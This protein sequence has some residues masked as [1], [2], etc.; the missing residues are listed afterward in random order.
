MNFKKLGLLLISG[1]LLSV[2]LLVP[3]L[4]VLIWIAFVPLLLLIS[5]HNL[6]QS[7]GFGLFFGII[8]YTS[9]LYWIAQYEIRILTIV[10]I[11]TAPYVALFALMTRLL[12]NHYP[13]E[14]IRILAV[15]IVWFVI[16]FLYSFTPVD[17]V[18]NQ[19]AFLQAPH[20]PGILRI[21][22]LSGIT[23]L[24]LLINS[25]I[26]H[27]LLNRRKL[28]LI[29]LVLI[30]LL[31]IVGMTSK[32]HF[33]QTQPLRVAVVQHNFPIS[34]KWRSE[35]REKIMDTYQHSIRQLGKT[36]DLI[37]FPQYGL[38]I[39]ALREPKFFDRLAKHLDTSIILGTY[40]PEVAGGSL[41]SGTRTDSALV[42]SG[43]HSVQEYQA[44][45]APPFRKIGQVLGKDR[46][47]L[48]IKQVKAGIM[49]CYED[50]HAQEGRRWVL[51]GAQI[52]ISLSNPGHFLQ[53]H[54]PFY[55]LTHDRI[56]AIE[57]GKYVIRASPNGFSALINPNGELIK[58]SKLNEKVMLQGV[59]YP[60]DYETWFVRFGALLPNA[61]AA[62]G[63]IL[64][65]APYFL[66]SINFLA[67][68][69]R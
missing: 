10:L 56:K 68:K 4:S 66:S 44:L 57:T 43:D 51:S 69:I 5:N 6:K 7:F 60:N 34:G 49:L 50:T 9:L 61:F 21:A 45:S 38:P 29:G 1:I 25:L 19:I 41:E 55:H 47:T 24:V 16:H 8:F 18:G 30:G 33:Y 23:F 12:W 31:L 67:R 15:P 63:I 2:S 54:L 13:K 37:A 46:K 65:I 27:Y 48:Q 35:N 42:F 26:A 11:L 28:P 59:I 22:G 64:L 32:F 52:L 17:I 39:D 53:T 14:I 40:I 58:V 62:L 36:V 20:F 3:S